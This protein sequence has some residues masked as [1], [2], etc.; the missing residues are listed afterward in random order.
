MLDN[1]PT[2]MMADC[3]VVEVYCLKL[4]DLSNLQLILLPAHVTSPAQPLDQ[5]IIACVKA[6][7]RRRSSSGY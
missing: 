6:H 1:A 3:E 4:I 2:H 5:G 7:Y